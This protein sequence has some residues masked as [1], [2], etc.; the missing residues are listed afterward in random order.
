[1]GSWILQFYR[2]QKPDSEGRKL[3]QIWAWD[4]DR[5]EQVHDFIQWMFPL[6]EPSSV[7]PDAPLLTPSDR[8][9]FATDPAL[10][11]AVRKSLAVFLDFLG[12]E[13]GVDGRVAKAPHFD[14]RAAVWK[15]TNHNWLRITRMLKSLR[16]L[17][18]GAEAQQVWQCLKQLHDH[19]GYVSDHSF[20]YWR[21]AVEGP[22]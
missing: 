21:D 11:S 19:D 20:A 16:L 12:L 9:A 14:R 4:Y 3:D 2:L 15:Y 5:L 6:D 1:M 10:R 13:L 7:N 18:Q 17:G 8:A 22:L